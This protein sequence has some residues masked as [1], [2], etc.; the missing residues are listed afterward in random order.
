[1]LSSDGTAL[2]GKNVTT[3][4]HYLGSTPYSDTTKTTN[5]TGQI[6]LTTSFGSPGKTA[7]TTRRSPVTAP[8]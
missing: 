6:T 5:A 8:I 4:Y 3:I 2:S 1:V 7:L